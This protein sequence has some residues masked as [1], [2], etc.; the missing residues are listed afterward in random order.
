M[1]TFKRRP[2]S[3]RTFLRGAAAR[4]PDVYRMSARALGPTA[5]SRWGA[6]VAWSMMRGSPR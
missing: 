3:R 6:R 5:L 2:L 1:S 4:Y